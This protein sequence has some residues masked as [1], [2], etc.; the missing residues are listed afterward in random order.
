MIGR[1]AQR[2]LTTAEEDAASAALRATEASGETRR[3]R[4]A[5]DVLPEG[6]I[7]CDED[8]HV[9][10]RNRTAQGLVEAR[11]AD[12]LVAKAVDELLERARVGVPYDRTVELFG[13]PARTLVIDAQPITG[14]TVAVI[15]DVTERRQLDAVR[16]DFVANVSHELRTPVGALSVLAEALADE[17][18]P[19]VIRRLAARVTAE[20]D[21]AERMIAD[22]LDLSRIES[23]GEGA[24]AVVA[25]DD[26]VSAACE[27]AAPRS[28]ARGVPI[29]PGG[30]EPGLAVVGRRSELVSAVAN[31][32]ENAVSYSDEG[33]SV[34]VVARADGD[35]VDFVVRDEGIGVPGRD[36]ERIFERFYR[37]DRARSRDTG[38]S[39][40]GLS[41]VRHVA[42]NHGGTVTVVSREGEGSTFVLRIPRSAG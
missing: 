23:E 1:A 15:R 28:A 32:L 22:L 2:R 40:L 29:V 18:D 19:A 41:I 33:T 35:W 31:L 5:L 7:V 24:L 10:Y 34:D 27:R 11:G 37:V 36:L 25:V 20:V 16:R 3:L 38:G 42:H 26:I 12:V 17:D 6:V 30:A 14:G 13:P 39:G 4:R 8:G 9:L 21:R